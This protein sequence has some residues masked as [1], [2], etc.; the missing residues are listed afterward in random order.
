MGIYGLLTLFAGNTA[1]SL[2]S[3]KL[4]MNNLEID[5]PGIP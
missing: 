5:P 4:V 1:I 3:S 2:S